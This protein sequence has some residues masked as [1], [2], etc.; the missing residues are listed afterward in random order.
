MLAEEDYYSKTYRHGLEYALTHFNI[1]KDAWIELGEQ[2]LDK[3]KIF[4]RNK[5]KELGYIAELPDHHREAY[6]ELL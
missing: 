5:L 1:H 4:E 6:L 2:V 3:Y